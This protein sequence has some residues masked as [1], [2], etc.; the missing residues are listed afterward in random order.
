M[1]CFSDQCLDYSNS[2]FPALTEGQTRWPSVSLLII[3]VNSLSL[4][5]EWQVT[6]ATVPLLAKGP[7]SQSSIICM[8]DLP[9][10]PLPIL[11]IRKICEG[12]SCLRFQKVQFQNLLTDLHRTIPDDVAF[13]ALCINEAEDEKRQ[14]YDALRL[15]GKE[16]SNIF[17]FSHLA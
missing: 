13:K 12:G 11:N 16:L 8:L 6:S 3:K 7:V 9:P 2:G 17:N 1:Q 10:H 15:P 14:H 5:Q 4:N